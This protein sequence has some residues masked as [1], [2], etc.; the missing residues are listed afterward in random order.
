MGRVW[1]VD[2]GA[3]SP[4]GL[5]LKILGARAEDL[6][7]LLHAVKCCVSVAA[8]DDVI[9]EAEADGLVK[10]LLAGTACSYKRRKDGGR[11]ILSFQHP[12][13]F[14]D[15]HRYVLPEPEPAIGIQ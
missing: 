5:K 9:R 7:L 13:D 15:L 2:C 12:G 14:C 10:V 6:E 4:L 3:G 11:S 1:E 8:Q